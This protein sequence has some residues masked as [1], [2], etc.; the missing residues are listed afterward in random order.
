VITLNFN[1][2]PNPKPCPKKKTSHRLEWIIIVLITVEVALAILRDGLPD[3]LNPWS[4]KHVKD[5]EME[6][7]IERLE[8][9]LV[10]MK[11]EK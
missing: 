6:D 5:E 8:K 11:A 3:A 1:L 7:R 9:I 4:S 2:N 10:A